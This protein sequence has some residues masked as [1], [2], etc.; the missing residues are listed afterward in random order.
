MHTKEMRFWL[1]IGVTLFPLLFILLLLS[2]INAALRVTSAP[3]YTFFAVPAL[4][5]TA[6]LVARFALDAKNIAW[7]LGGAVFAIAFVFTAATFV[8]PVLYHLN[9]FMKVGLGL[10]VILAVLGLCTIQVACIMRKR[11]R[12]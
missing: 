10:L 9:Q 2:N 8:I 5:L 3:L 6:V 1:I 7:R 4:L 11:E 12:S